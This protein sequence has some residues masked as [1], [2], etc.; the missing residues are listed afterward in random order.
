M[1][2]TL[3]ASSPDKDLSNYVTLRQ[4]QSHV[5]IPLIQYTVTKGK[6]KYWI[7]GGPYQLESMVSDCTV[8]Y[9]FQPI[10]LY[11]SCLGTFKNLQG[12]V[13][14]WHPRFPHGRV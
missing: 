10:L 7:A 6:T 1:V 2:K 9:C 5:T 4:P 13:T 14:K 3:S 8:P 11:W 12:K